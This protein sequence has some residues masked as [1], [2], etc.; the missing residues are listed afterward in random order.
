[1]KELNEKNAVRQQ[2]STAGNLNTRISI[3]QKYSVNSQPFGDWIYEN[4]DFAPGFKILELGCGTGDTWVRHA[5]SLPQGAAL[6]LTDFSA[7]ML[8]TTKRNLAGMPNITFEVVDIQAIPYADNSFDAVIANMMLYHVPDLDKA[9]SEVRRVLKP[10]GT[11]YCA[12]YG[13]NGIVQYLSRILQDFEVSDQLNKNFTLQNGGEKLRRHFASVRR[14]DRD[15]ALNVTNID[16]IVDYLYSLTSM[17]NLKLENRSAITEALTAH[18]QNGVLHIPKEYG[19][20][21][22]RK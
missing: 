9:L 11:F 20:F 5:A 6:H 18:M 17:S 15:D 13:E 2:Y 14:C 16:D 3:H 19:M 12:T 21:L 8:E 10:G 22:C 4:Y 7:G 1:M